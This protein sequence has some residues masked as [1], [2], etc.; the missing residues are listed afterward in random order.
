MS[1]HL[2]C[3]STIQGSELPVLGQRYPK[4]GDLEADLT[5]L[6]YLQSDE[7]VCARTSQCTQDGIPLL[8]DIIHPE[9]IAIDR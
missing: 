3:F 5:F 4:S 6:V 7:E 2:Q 1:L 9:W 8:S